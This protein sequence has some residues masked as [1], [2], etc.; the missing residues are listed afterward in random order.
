MSRTVLLGSRENF[1]WHSMQEIIPAL[2]EC[3]QASAR[4][5][6]H[7]VAAV[8]V[9]SARLK[10]YL[11]LLLK[12]DNVVLTSFTPKLSRLGETLRARFAIEARLFFH[13]H[14]QATI[15]FW[16]LHRWGLGSVLREDDVFVS[17]CTR[18][19]RAVEL[20]FE[21]ARAECVPFTFS[22]ADPLVEPLPLPQ[23]NPEFVFVGRLSAQKKLEVLISAL[24]RVPEARLSLFGRA[25]NLGSPNMG[26]R[27]AGYDGR[28]RE[29]AIELGLAGRVRFHGHVAREEL[30]RYLAR[31]PHIFVSPSAHS[32][33]NFGMAAFRSLCMG[34]PAVLSDWGG[35][36]DFAR[37]FPGRVHFVAVDS[38]PG[39]SAEELAR[40]LVRARENYTARAAQVPEIYRRE[41]IGDTL[42]ALASEPVR[43]GRPL[44]ATELARR[45]LRN[46]ERY[47]RESGDPCRIFESYEDPDAR[48]LLQSYGMRPAP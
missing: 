20:S 10:D 46:R 29:L 33:E 16:P 26:L 9:D 36:A 41:T 44:R 31:T 5:E 23:G 1:V 4:P 24:A 13:V 25:D 27:C 6:S 14:N 43:P 40:A 18:D 7:E 45:I 39:V 32:D 34:A 48:A 11:P 30:N 42:L 12:A 3:W 8:D 21:N 35:H 47:G 19:A 37:A 15:G 22:S 17:S 38:G 2:H 28:L